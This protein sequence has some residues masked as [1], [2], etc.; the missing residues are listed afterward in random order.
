MC[1]YILFLLTYYSRIEDTS[2]PTKIYP[3]PHMYVVKD[4]VPDM[5]NFYAQYMSIEPYLKKRGVKEE[6]V[7]KESYPQTV[8]DRAKLV[9]AC[10][11]WL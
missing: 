7:G 9:S 10:V 3:L 4:I 1:V 5:G 11:N 6:D 2:K 8:E